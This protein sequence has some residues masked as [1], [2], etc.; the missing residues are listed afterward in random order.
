[1]YHRLLRPF[2]F[3]ADFMV[4][5]SWHMQPLFGQKGGLKISGFVIAGLL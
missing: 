3:G 2:G 4:A 1:M 5:G